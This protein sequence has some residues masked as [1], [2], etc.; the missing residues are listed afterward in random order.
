MTKEWHDMDGTTRNWMIAIG[1]GVAT[2]VLTVGLG[3]KS[4]TAGVTAGLV[5]IVFFGFFLE[6][7]FGGKDANTQM[8][9]L[10]AA[11]T[12]TKLPTNEEV[13]GG[14]PQ[15]DVKALKLDGLIDWLTPKK[16]ISNDDL[17]KVTGVRLDDMSLEK[18][19]MAGIVQTAAGEKPAAKPAVV[20]EK[21]AVKAKA[22]TEG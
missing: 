22:K 10:M 8:Q 17:A 14:Q 11:L 9:N 2:M 13:V 3:D 21:P 4:P 12:P 20:A 19:G 5:A 6:W 16:L 18:V 1:V 7:A 15:F